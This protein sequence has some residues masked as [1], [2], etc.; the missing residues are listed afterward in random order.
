MPDSDLSD[1][2]SR[3]QRL[4]YDRFTQSLPLMQAGLG[5]LVLIGVESPRLGQAIEAD[6][7]ERIGEGEGAGLL[8]VDHTHGLPSDFAKRM[9]E[10]G[11]RQQIVLVPAYDV[12][13]EEY[14]RIAAELLYQRD[15]LT[16]LA[17]P[18]IFLVPI[19]LYDTIQAKAYDFIS[20]AGYALRLGDQAAQVERDFSPPEKLPVEIEEFQEAVAEL[21]EYQQ[22]P[23]VHPELLMKK[24]LKAGNKAYAISRVQ[25]AKSY[26]EKS[27]EL[28]KQNGD[29][30]HEGSALG[31][32]GNVLA[33]LGENDQALQFHY[34]ALKIAEKLDH[35]QGMIA[36]LGNIGLIYQDMGDLKMAM[37]IFQ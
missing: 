23:E 36:S 31:G 7:I 6:L 30:F 32:L 2:L 12:P 15:A 4:T 18:F 37:Q 8:W 33:E 28:A 3:K 19:G 5:Y 1:L 27:L 35:H 9:I 17:L 21:E 25:F 14:V 26:F 34:D 29:P 20:A 22:R 13:E 16:R 11:Q 24:L 10:Y